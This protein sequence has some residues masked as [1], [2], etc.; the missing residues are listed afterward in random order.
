MSTIPLVVLDVGLRLSGVIPIS[1]GMWGGFHVYGRLLDALTKRY[2]FRQI[3]LMP[4]KRLAVNGHY[5][6]TEN[7]FLERRRRG[8]MRFMNSIVRHPVLRD[9]DIVVA[10]ITIP[11]VPVVWLFNCRNL[12]SGV[13]QHQFRLSKS[14]PSVTYLWI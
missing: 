11:T 12:L 2:P 3:P 8:L 6:S 13:N 5:L 4:P 1:L 9:D 7:G 14:S 10:F